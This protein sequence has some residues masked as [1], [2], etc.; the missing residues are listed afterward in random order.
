MGKAATLPNQCKEYF[1]LFQTL[2]KSLCDEKEWG[3]MRPE[4]LV[5]DCSL[6]LQDYETTEVCQ[7][8]RTRPSSMLTV[9]QELGVPYVEDVVVNSLAIIMHSTLFSY[10]PSS[11]NWEFPP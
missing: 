7:A 8:A 5:S 4:R 11:V 9:E 10:G 1:T 2:L 6:I 3:L